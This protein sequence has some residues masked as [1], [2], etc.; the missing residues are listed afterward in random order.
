MLMSLVRVEHG[1][2]RCNRRFRASGLHRTLCGR[3]SEEIERHPVTVEV[4]GSSPVVRALDGGANGERPR[5]KRG[6]LQGLAGSTPAPS[7]QCWLCASART[8]DRPMIAFVSGPGIIV[9]TV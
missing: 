3:S 8:S 4:A 2:P 1:E 6:G 5:W 9:Y 7:A